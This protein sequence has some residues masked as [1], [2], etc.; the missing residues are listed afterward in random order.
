MRDVRTFGLIAAWV[1][2]T[3]LAVVVAAAAVG[4]VREGV[5]DQP[6]AAAPVVR[7]TLADLGLTTT[8][9]PSTTTT[10][11][12][13]TTT[14]EAPPSTTTTTVASSSTTTTTRPPASTTTTTKAPDVQVL[15]PYATA[16]GTVTISVAE[17]S[18]WLVAAVP[19]AGYRAD[20]EKAGPN[21]VEVE[22]ES[23]GT[24]IKFRARWDHGELLV[25]IESDD[26]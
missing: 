18:V 7:N 26:D 16:G 20:V 19:N 10:V 6:Q 15:P 8:S 13:T 12:G 14:S 22:F 17:P 25:E 3:A 2:A 11:P 24:E 21:V 23:E 9:E 4:S 5:T 1:G